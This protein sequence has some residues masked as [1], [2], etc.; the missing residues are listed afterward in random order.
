MV[1]HLPSDIQ[2]KPNGLTYH[3]WKNSLRGNGIRWFIAPLSFRQRTSWPNL[4]PTQRNGSLQQHSYLMLESIIK[5]RP[6]NPKPQ[7]LHLKRR[8]LLLPREMTAQ[9]NL[10]PVWSPI[11]SSSKCVVLRIQ[12]WVIVPDHR[13]RVVLS[14]NLLKSSVFCPKRI[15]PRLPTKW[16]N[17]L[18]QRKYFSGWVFLAR[19][20][21]HGVMWTWSTPRQNWRF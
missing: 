21:L 4:S 17:F 1:N 11:D 12:N 15:E 7:L 14:I 13:Q 10:G 18:N 20:V 3:G 9:G 2:T 19:G 5:G 8:R 6:L 16:I